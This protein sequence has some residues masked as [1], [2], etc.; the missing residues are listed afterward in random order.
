[1]LVL[2]EDSSSLI[3]DAD[4]YQTLTQHSSFSPQKCRRPLG[5]EEKYLRVNLLARA[6]AEYCGLCYFQYWELE[7]GGALLHLGSGLVAFAVMASVLL[8]IVKGCPLLLLFVCRQHLGCLCTFPH[9]C[10]S[11]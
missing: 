6:K 4:L 7:M 3:D 1:M 8:C 11:V 2:G 10:F 9:L 5:G